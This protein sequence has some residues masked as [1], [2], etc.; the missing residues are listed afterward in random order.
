MD[1]LILFLLQ[2]LVG[3]ALSGAV[4]YVAAK[5]AE[6][7]E[8]FARSLVSLIRALTPWM[9]RIFNPDTALSRWVR[10]KGINPALAD[11]ALEFIADAFDK[12]AKEN[13]PES[14]PHA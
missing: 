8:R 9:R 12:W 2:A 6:Q 7:G 13:A 4:L 3:V 5:S 1:E 14:T 11:Q 10:S